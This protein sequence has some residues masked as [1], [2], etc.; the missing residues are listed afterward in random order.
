MRIPFHHAS[1]R[2]LY[3]FAHSPET[4][5]GRLRRHL[6]TCE[7]CRNDVRAIRELRSKVSD[8]G[9]SRPSDALL[10]R[11][12]RRI[13]NN[14]PVVLPIADPSLQASWQV[15]ASI[16][17]VVLICALV[18]AL[19]PKETVRGS[20]LYGELRFTPNHLVTGKRIEVEYR[21]GNILSGFNR[22]VLRARFRTI[23][24]QPYGYATKQT[25]AAELA[26]DARG[27]FRGSFTVPDSVVYAAFA[28]ENKEGTRVDHNEWRLWDLT[29]EA[30]SG[31][32]SFEALEQQANDLFGRSM[33]EALRVTQK[34]AALYPELPQS[35]G[36]V[37]ALERFMLGKPH[38]DSTMASH[39]ARLYRF[40]DE[41]RKLPKV[42]YDEME[43]IRTY[44]VQVQD[45]GAPRVREIGR[46]WLKREE[47]DSSKT[48]QA[49]IMRGF[50]FSDSARIA[51]ARFLPVLDSLWRADG[52]VLSFLPNNAWVF[53]RNARDDRA[54]LL[55]TDRLAAY[56]PG[57]ATYYYGELLKMPSLRDSALIRL[58]MSLPALYSRQDSLRPL[59]LSVE[60][61]AR[62]DARTASEILK[63]I[64]TALVAEGKIREG[65]DT[66]DLAAR[67][68]WDAN[69]FRQV[70]EATLAAGDTSGS[71]PLFA[72]AAANPGSTRAFSDSILVRFRGSV[73]RPRWTALVDSAFREMRKRVLRDAISRSYD[74][75]ARLIGSSGRSVALGQLARGKV[76]VFTFWSRYCGPSRQQQIPALDRLSTALA[77]YGVTLVPISEEPPSPDLSNFLRTQNVT[78]PMYYDRWREAGRAFSQWGTP[79]YDIVDSEGRIRFARTSQAKVLAQ[80]AALSQEHNQPTN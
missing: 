6:E 27:V 11:I 14:E 76:V 65:L 71:L 3:E 34:T 36:P 2:E 23:I 52:R 9:P 22:V 75:T 41:F 35:W 13:T 47:A 7:Q 33:E 48:I 70:A 31:K 42:P 15:A 53:S 50:A 60:E 12:K 20:T 64:G 18:W 59:E 49:R 30:R 39:R 25:V 72:F 69:L 77:R 8:I 56:M 21:A 61:Q 26:P 57:L 62:I 58:R 46:Y 28:V 10:E 43:G 68:V 55:W 67:D 5:N 74:S 17:A 40:D 51:P 29:T 32:A 19:W 24:D 73:Q 45:S 54:T 37:V 1:T 38:D 63:S 78:I 80:A 66:L 79:Q 16:A 44:A 4:G